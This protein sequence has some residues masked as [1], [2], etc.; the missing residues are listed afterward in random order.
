MKKN[1]QTHPNVKDCYRAPKAIELHVEP[2]MII[3]Q[4]D[5]LEAYEEDEDKFRF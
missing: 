5:Q 1:Y 3:C 4:S 2:D